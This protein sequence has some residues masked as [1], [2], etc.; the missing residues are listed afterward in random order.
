MCLFVYTGAAHP[1]EIWRL[2]WNNCCGLSRLRFCSVS[3]FI[4]SVL[5][6]LWLNFLLRGTSWCD[7]KW[8]G[9][10]GSIPEWFGLFEEKGI[11]L[12]PIKCFMLMSYIN[13]KNPC[14][15]L[16]NFRVSVLFRSWKHWNCCFDGFCFVWTWFLALLSLENACKTYGLW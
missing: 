1:G 5:P 10:F 14:F 8:C 4:G 7:T 3:L 12:L 15:Q 16:P 13:P 6:S 9:Y 11:V 2:L